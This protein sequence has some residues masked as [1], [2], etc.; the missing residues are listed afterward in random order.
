MVLLSARQL[1]HGRFSGNP[2]AVFLQSADAEFAHTATYVNSQFSVQMVY[3]LL[4]EALRAV[5][6][7]R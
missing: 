3:S 7:Q 2:G 5:E 4:G 6:W 1:G